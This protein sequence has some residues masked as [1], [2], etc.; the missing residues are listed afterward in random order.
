MS[1]DNESFYSADSSASSCNDSFSSL[2]E[3]LG[4][5]LRQRFDTKSC[6]LFNVCHLNAQSIPSHY[7]ELFDTFSLNN[8]HA[9]LVSETWLKPELPS[10]TYSLPGFVLLRNDRIGRRG[11]GVAIYLRADFPFKILVSST[12]NDSAEFLFIEV[13]V[14][15]AKAILGVAY[16]PPTLDYFT[17]FESVLES[18]GSEYA[19]HIIMGDF[20]TNLLVPNSSRSRKLLHIVQSA[21]L[22]ILPL[23]PTHHNK[24]GDD[25]WLDLLLTSNP[26]LVSSH[27]QLDAPGFSHHDLIYLSYLLK[28][29]KPKPMIQFRRAFARMNSEQLQRDAVCIDWSPLQDATTV[30]DKVSVFNNIV[31]ELYDR[32][33]P[34]RRVKLKRPPAPWMNQEI[35]MAMRRRDRAFRRFKGDRSEENWDSFKTH[36]NR[37]NQKIRNAKRRHI[38]SNITSSSSADIWKFLK[39]LGI[40][41]PAHSDLPNTIGLDEVNGYFSTVPLLDSQTKCETVDYLNGLTR[42][43][44][45]PFVFTPVNSEEIKKIILSIKSKAVGCDNISRHMI[46][47]ALDQLL[48]AIS[49][50]VNFSLSSRMFPSLWRKAYVRP[51]PKV[52]NPTL[53]SHFRPISILPFLSKVLEA[54][55]HKQFSNFIYQNSLISPFQ[56]GFRPGHSTVTALLKVTDDIRRGM[57]DT[58]VTILVLIDFSNAFNT[59]SHEIL[60]SIL[61]N[62]MV[63]HEVLEWFSSYLQGRQQSVRVGDS[64]SGWCDLVA[65]VPQGGILSPLLFSVFINFITIM[66]QC[67]YHLYA[68]DL[69]LYCR[70][71]VDNISDAIEELNRDLQVIKNW[72]D[73]F[74]IAVNPT[75]CQAIIIGSPHSLRKLDGLA[76]P[77]VIFNNTVIPFS[78]EVKDLGL[79]V[80]TCL[81][82]RKQVTNV[83]QKVTGTLRSLYRLKNF[84]PAHIKALLVQSLIFPLIDYADVC[85]Y[86]LNA[87]LLNKLD[88]LLNNCIRF[89][90]NLRK[91]DHVSEH[92]SLLK[93]LPI[94]QRRA[95]RALTT[96]FSF[97]CNPSSPSYLMSEIQFLGSGHNKNL[98]S[99][100]NRLLQCPLHRSGLIHSSF[101]VQ[102][103]SLW[104]TLPPNIR[105]AT[106]RLSFKQKARDYIREKLADLS[107]H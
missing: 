37:C 26:S 22:H 97:L 35:L 90:F 67:T 70:S 84:L 48:P 52:S 54:C 62:L 2:T 42:S 30:D 27:G 104:N 105:M 31:T 18:L 24:N 89:V 57:E 94:R 15:G 6:R 81:D 87:D 8:V 91:Y 13:C 83:S 58:K 39:S 1:S 79:Y 5:Q 102:A 19:H 56:S 3:T 71:S 106:S 36:R 100:N 85:Y 101:F 55:V 68:D 96:L 50:I 53:S 82:W 47:S 99:S 20:N 60:L 78:S 43:N 25:T 63:S 46:V 98:R 34:V 61:S 10:T 41:K 59:V 107:R 103:I 17:E 9:V 64:E 92:R 29:P 14:K 40:G 76:V 28:P 93:W 21:S 44:I 69:Q 7:T 74:G 33:A 95:L 49:H 88:R 86:D 51:L 72:S 12:P 75:K 66:L 4:D 16:C 38:L 65:G 73:R 32:H 45:A 77:P 80:D 23:Q 11:G